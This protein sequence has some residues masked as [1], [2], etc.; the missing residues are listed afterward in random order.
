MLVALHYPVSG[1][2]SSDKI[3]IKMVAGTTKKYPTRDVGA[4]AKIGLLA[5]R[6]STQ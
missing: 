1:F 2:L 6:V 4:R 5:Y 3:T